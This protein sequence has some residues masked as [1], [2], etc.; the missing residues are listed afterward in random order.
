MANEREGYRYDQGT[1]QKQVSQNDQA[2][3]A[4]DDLEAGADDVEKVKGGRRADPCDG[5]E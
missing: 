5:G 1:D 3:Q 2:S 4:F